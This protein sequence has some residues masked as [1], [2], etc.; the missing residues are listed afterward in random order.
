MQLELEH[1]KLYQTFVAFVP[2]QVLYWEKHNLQ[3]TPTITSHIHP[4]WFQAILMSQRSECLYTLLKT[5]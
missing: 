4:P 3:I 5:R 2:L 1:L